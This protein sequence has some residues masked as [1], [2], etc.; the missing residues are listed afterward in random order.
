MRTQKGNFSNAIQCSLAEDWANSVYFLIYNLRRRQ[1]AV[2]IKLPRAK[3]RPPACFFAQYCWPAYLKWCMSLSL[4]LCCCRSLS[5]SLSLC[6]VLGV[7]VFAWKGESEDD[8]WWC[9]DRCVNTEGWQANMVRVS[10]SPRW[11]TL[12]G[13]RSAFQ[14]RQFAL[15]SCPRSWTTGETSPTGS[16]R[17]TPAC[18][19]RPAASWRKVSRGCTGQIVPSLWSTYEDLGYYLDGENREKQTEW[20]SGWIFIIPSF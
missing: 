2:C 12:C 17:S 13:G 5:L 18:S 8:F 10:R 11:G 9:I 15:C 14:R 19:R 20:T 7:S 3:H 16:T 6:H 4:S 1:A